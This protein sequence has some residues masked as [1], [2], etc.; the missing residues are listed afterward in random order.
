MI[1]GADPA[2]IVIGVVT[3]III[4]LVVA[5]F[6][7]AP[8]YPY[9]PRRLLSAAELKFFRTLEPLIPNDLRLSLKPRLGDIIDV[10]YVVRE[11]DFQ[12]KGKYGAM[13][14][15]KHL[16]FVIYDPVDSEVVL[17]IELDD[18]SHLT[19]DA[20]QRDTFKNK[21]LDAAGVPLLRIKAR[22]YYESKTLAKKLEPF[23]G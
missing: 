17:C 15:S 6:I 20:Q 23:L 9:I 7:T 12:W 19:K 22:A 8:R 21:A 3:A 14:W 5:K 18:S 16:D 10:D 4:L 11:K 1:E 13:I 2:H